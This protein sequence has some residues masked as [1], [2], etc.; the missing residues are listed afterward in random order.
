MADDQA[1]KDAELQKTQQELS[2]LRAKAEELEKIKPEYEKLKD[3]D[4]NFS[5]LRESKG[6]EVREKETEVEKLKEEM[7]TWKQEQERQISSWQEAQLKSA[8]E[9]VLTHLSG[10]DKDLREKIEYEAGLLKMDANSPEELDAKYAK[11]YTLVKG[12][13]PTPSPFSGV[14]PTTTTYFKEEK[15]KYTETEEGITNLKAWFPKLKV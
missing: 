2:E 11:A 12:E 15:K 9:Q 5:K 8:K 7:V 10:K 4:I 3:K 6:Q 14:M 13:R 1:A